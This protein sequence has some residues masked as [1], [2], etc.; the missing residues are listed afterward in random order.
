MVPHIGYV[1]L[2]LIEIGLKTCYNLDRLSI[3]KTCHKSCHKSG[4]ATRKWS[5]L[6]SFCNSICHVT[7]V[8][9]KPIIM[10]YNV[11]IKRQQLANCFEKE[12]MYPFPKQESTKGAS[13]SKKSHLLLSIYCSCRTVCQYE[14]EDPVV[15]CMRCYEWFHQKCE[16]I[17]RKVFTNKAAKDLASYIASDLLEHSQVK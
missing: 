12:M 3:G 1:Y 9:R 5:R 11:P 10:F 16:K 15:E 4:A 13:K 17:P 6:W 7:S 14:R 8:W 2:I